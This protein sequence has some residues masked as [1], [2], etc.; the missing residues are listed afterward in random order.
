M[1]QPV[2][3]R[4]VMIGANVT[5]RVKQAVEEEARKSDMS[6]SRYV[7]ELLRYQMESLGYSVE[8]FPVGWAKRKAPFNGCPCICALHGIVDSCSC[9]NHPKRGPHDASKRQTGAEGVT[10]TEFWPATADPMRRK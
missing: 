5:E 6:V 10:P 9:P 3:D 7:Y 1:A 2:K 8:S 4:L